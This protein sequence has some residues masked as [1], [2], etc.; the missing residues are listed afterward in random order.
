MSLLVVIQLVRE[1]FEDSAV[2][3]SRSS[4]ATPF[5]TTLMSEALSNSLE[6]DETVTRSTSSNRYGFI[7]VS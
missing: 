4:M 6:N 5:D 7:L 3:S 1:A 2:E